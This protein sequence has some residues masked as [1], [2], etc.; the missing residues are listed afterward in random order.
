VHESPD[1]RAQAGAAPVRRSRLRVLERSSL[2]PTYVGIAAVALGF[3]LIAIAWAK[4][5]AL[6]N[7]A[8][9][10][11]YVV[12]AGMSGLAVVMCGVLIVNVAAKRQDAAERA[13][14][15]ERLTSIM[16]ELKEALGTGAGRAEDG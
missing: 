8:L 13:R 9:Q 7:V 15:M 2:V 11:P 3:A 10:L 14:Q 4:V 1:P 5:A 16:A 12:S 6:T